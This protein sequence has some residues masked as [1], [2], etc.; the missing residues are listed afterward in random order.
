VLNTYHLLRN[1]QFGIEHRGTGRAPDGV[2][3]QHNKHYVKY[4]TG[5]NSPDTDG[6]PAPGIP[7]QASLG[8]IWFRTYHKGWLGSRRQIQLLR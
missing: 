5:T 3:T 8:A 1:H 2:V 7:V 6:H 4:I